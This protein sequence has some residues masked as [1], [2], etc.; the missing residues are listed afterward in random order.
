MSAPA[1]SELARLEQ[2]IDTAGVAAGIEARLPVGVRPRQLQA[3]TLLLGMLIVA[4]DGRPALLSWVHRA[5]L[6]LSEEDQRRL[7]VLAPTP[8]GGEHQL[9]YRQLEYTFARVV[10]ALAKHAPDGAPSPALSEV[11]DRLLEASV[12][13]LGQ[14]ASESLAVDWTALEAWAR[15]P[16]TDRPEEGADGEA[17]WGH[18]TVTH[19]GQTDTFYGYY[20]QALTCVPEET[21]PQVPELVRRI[22]LA[23][24][25][26]DP[27]AQIIGVLERMR[28]DG[29]TLGDL[30]ADSGYA[31]R[32]AHTFA[33]PAR[34]LGARLVIDL[35]PNDRGPKT[36][37]QGAVCA[38]GA[39]YCPATPHT[40][41]ELGPLGPGASPEQAAQHDQ[42]CR[43]LH[44][45]KLAPHAAPD[46]DGYHRVS[47]P[48]ITGK[49]RCP[50]RPQS[51]SLG[52]DRP[53]ITAPPEHPPVCCT[54]QTITVPPS[55]NAKTT[56]KHDYPSAQHRRSYTRRT[57][58]ERTFATLTDPA[59]TNLARGF[60]RLTGLT[61]LTL[62]TTTATIARNLRCAD[63]H[64][65]RQADN[66]HRA[67]HGLPPKTRTRR[68]QPLAALTASARSP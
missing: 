19:P 1:A 38:N 52:Y 34:A 46:P 58:S 12:Q 4:V 67:A 3:R 44:R 22:H 68:R 41:L 39:L 2:I 10:R 9:T 25:R 13:I 27:P 30:L 17:A 14:P 59:A 57:A 7:G 21:G 54:Q 62:F 24:C 33:L 43:E 8:H 32:Q 51:L 66:Q 35:H 48:A 23:S 28:R 15:P 31:Y 61:P 56:Q 18:R 26:H 60:C 37:H 11:V 16:R 29:I 36:T 40:L 64:H 6:E 63:A 65:A 5:L 47:C 45:H 50:L 20:L 55:V 49:I 42:R 53:T